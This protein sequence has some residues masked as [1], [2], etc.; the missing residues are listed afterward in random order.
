MIKLGVITKVT[1]PTDWC[2]RLD[3]VPKPNGHVRI[4]VN[5]TKLNANACREQ[6]F[7]LSIESLL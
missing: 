1:E 2:A 6:H 7:L 4:Y 3:I 5:L